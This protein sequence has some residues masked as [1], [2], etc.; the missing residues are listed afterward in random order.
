MVRMPMYSPLVVL[1]FLGACAGLVL[2]A[3]I[4]LFGLV[5]RRFMVAKVAAGIAATAVALYALLLFSF[6]LASQ[7]RTLLSGQYKYFCEVDCHIAY[8]VQSVTQ[9]RSLGSG[10]VVMNA[11]GVFYIVRLQTWFDPSTIS[12][13]RGNGPLAPSPREVVVVDSNGHEYA[14]LP[15]AQ[16]IL[17]AD[18]NTTPLTTPLRPSESFLTDFVFDLPPDAP[19]PR[20]L[21]KD[22]DPITAVFIGHEDSPLHKKIFFAL[23]GN[24]SAYRD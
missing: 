4:C 5:S 15:Q 22:A 6:S 17:G 3:V 21:V 7:E 14:P 24:R 16:Q 18:A 10:S 13:H 8:S 2:M 20:L 11:Q 9:E 12:A 23:T 19:N 1:A